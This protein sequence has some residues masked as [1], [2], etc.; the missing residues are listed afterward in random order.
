MTTRKQ[1]AWDEW[2]ALNGENARRFAAHR[3]IPLGTPERAASLEAL[4]RW[5]IE[6]YRPTDARLWPLVVKEGN[7]HNL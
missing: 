5:R 7:G 6:V 1:S 4:N 2:N 3:A